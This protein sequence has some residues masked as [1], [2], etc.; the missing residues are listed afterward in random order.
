MAAN[1][2]ELARDLV[3][4]EKEK[5]YSP[6]DIAEMFNFSLSHVYR[7]VKKGH[8]KTTPVKQP[9][10]FNKKYVITQSDL[11]D[12]KRNHQFKDYPKHIK[13]IQGE[14]VRIDNLETYFKT[15]LN[16]KPPK[17]LDTDER[18]VWL[19]G[20]RTARNEIMELLSN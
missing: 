15:R 9:A 19:N 16:P 8:L 18:E 3:D 13:V 5:T 14:P 20:W 2:N 11:D 12:F 1:C 6:N 17:F 7:M 4:L 10:P